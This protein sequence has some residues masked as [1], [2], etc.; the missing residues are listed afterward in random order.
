MLRLLETA[1]QKVIVQPQLLCS[2]VPG[3]D[4]GL[5]LLGNACTCVAM[6]NSQD[7]SGEKYVQYETSQSSGKVLKLRSLRWNANPGVKLLLSLSSQK[8]A[9]LP[10]WQL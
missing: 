4:R 6:E 9:V 2:P 3:T 7:T 5:V 1:V 8:H 10:Y